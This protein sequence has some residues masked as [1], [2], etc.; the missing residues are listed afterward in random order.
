MPAG[1]GGLIGGVGVA[2]TSLN[3]DVAVYGAQSVA[4]PALHAAKQ[5]GHL[6]Q[7]PIQESLADGLAG[8]VESGSITLDLVQ[9]YVRE[10]ALVEEAE[11][12]EAM[13]FL[14]EHEHVLVEG[15]AAVGV[16]ALRQRRLT[17]SGPTVVLLT[18]RNVAASVL[19][20]YVL[21]P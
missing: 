19:R 1:G 11:I 7:V 17:L 13:R 14:L 20:Q 2:A 3:P 10:I 16:A 9:R 12:A 5:A 6:V 8:N 18:G 4:S 15:A 21:V